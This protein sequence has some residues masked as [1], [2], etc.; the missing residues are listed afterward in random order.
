MNDVLAKPFT[1]DGM[2][3]ILKKH[4]PYLLKNPPPADSDELMGGPIHAP[5]PVSTPGYTSSSTMSMGGPLGPTGIATSS[6]VKYE[7]TPIQS[8]ATTTSWHSPGQMGHAQTSPHMDSGGFLA[9]AVNGQQMVL[10]PGGTQRPTF[11]GG[12]PP[13][14]SNPPIRGMPDMGDD[15]PGKR[16]RVYA[17]QGQFAQ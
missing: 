17:P 11:Q 15:R 8:P 13:Q 6:A 12:P 4:L 7:T 9:G 16:Q 2:I 3:R 5:Q 14:I 10:T 1:K